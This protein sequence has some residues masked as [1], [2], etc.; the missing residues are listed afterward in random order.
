MLFLVANHQSTK[1]TFMKLNFSRVMIIR[2]LSSMSITTATK[3]TTT[4]IW[5]RF[6]PLTSRISSWQF[7]QR[8]VFCLITRDKPKAMKIKHRICHNA[9][10][11]TLVTPT[12]HHQHWDASRSAFLEHNLVTLN[13]A[14]VIDG[15]RLFNL[16]K[17]YIKKGLINLIDSKFYKPPKRS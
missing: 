3:T 7:W 14:L 6:L 9:S 17:S 11:L 1:W 15:R 4:T 8:C 2:W 12:G 10:C 5:G 13:D 16:N